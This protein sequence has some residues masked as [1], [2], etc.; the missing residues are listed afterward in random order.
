[1]QACVSNF[2]S[3]LGDTKWYVIA[4]P[5]GVQWGAISLHVVT[6]ML[7]GSCMRSTVTKES[8]SKVMDRAAQHRCKSGA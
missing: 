6:V 3:G 8:G 1:M 5:G 4:E 7:L 2:C